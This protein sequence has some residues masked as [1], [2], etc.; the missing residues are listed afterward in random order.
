MKLSCGLLLFLLLWSISAMAVG[1]NP[2]HDWRSFDSQH[3]VVHFEAEDRPQALQAA[4][5]AERVL[6]GIVKDLHW[7]PRSKTHLI[8]F[9][10]YD[11]A[12]GFATPLPFS[13][14]GIFL[15]PP[16]DGELLENS[17]WLEL[18]ISHELVHIVHL[19]KVRGAPKFLQNIFG[20]YPL[21][22][23]NA[24]QPTWLIEGLATYHESE[25][26]QHRGRLDNALSDAYMRLE[27][28]NGAK[29]L[30]E[31]NSSGR[32]FPI[33]KAYLY[34]AYFYR[35]LEQRYGADA[36]YRLVENYSDNIIPF[37][38]HSN[39]VAVTKK[40]MDELWLE[41][42]Q[43][44]NERFGGA[45]KNAGK[46]LLAEPAWQLETPVLAAD[47]SLYAVADDGISRPYLSRL[48]SDGEW[49]HLQALQAGARIDIN[50]NGEVLIAQ[51]EICDNYHYYYD[52]YRWSDADGLTRLSQCGRYRF[53]G[54]RG[55]NALLALRNDSGRAAV[56]LLDRNGKETQTL[57][58]AADSEALPA[59]AVSQDG[60]R[61][62]WLSKHAGQWRVQELQLADGSVQ[63][64]LRSDTALLSLRYLPEN[65]DLLWV[66][67]QNGVFNVERW[68]RASTKTVR[69][70]DANAAVLA[71]SGAQAGRF[72]SL[73]LVHGGYQLYQHPL[74]ALAGSPEAETLT[75]S[76]AA[77]AL[78]TEA[79]AAEVVTTTTT[80]E[81]TATGANP[82][83]L[84]VQDERDYSA[85]ETLAPRAW[86]PTAMVADGALAF[87]VEL[88]GQDAIGWHQYTLSPQYEFSEGELLG[89]LV[90]GYDQR[91]F[92][93]V[94][95]EM[96]VTDSIEN[97]DDEE[98]IVSYELRTAAQWIS[99]APWLRL[100]HRL[101]FGIGA[102]MA[103]ETYELV[104]V[105]RITLQ[106]EKLAAAFFSYDSRRGNWWSEGNNS[107]QYLSLLAESYD[108]FDGE[109]EGRVYRA[110]WRG[111]WA[112]GVTSLALR[113]T[114][115]KG[116]ERTEPFELGGSFNSEQFGIPRL[117]ERDL[118]LRG[119]DNGEPE[120]TGKRA[121]IAGIEWRTPLV[122]LDRHLMVPPI[123]LNRLSA[124]LFYEAGA[125]WTDASKPEQYYRSAG[126][127]LL[128]ELKLGYRLG[129]L[130]R[131][132]FAR[133]LDEPGGDEVYLQLGRSF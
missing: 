82:A 83:T 102:A 60:A 114:E 54:W 129:L 108:P 92:F 107:G 64:L 4:A 8:L 90:Y 27:V 101:R 119:Y 65:N 116:D 78:A 49:Q 112:L 13:H 19:D 34:G 2:S 58:Q 35:F 57:Y 118:A 126:V 133:G 128:A 53:A 51:P 121:R 11:L 70:T 36:V 75:E 84:T 81:V 115:A 40:P 106:D 9:D 5:I 76:A 71:V 117:N 125:A 104:D 18:V 72:V 12:N 37:R 47:G 98:E 50:S 86:F 15:T 132:G 24:W 16:D 63:T 28:Q 73:Q 68:S 10:D 7:Q 89:S 100:D 111:Q 14:T 32:A 120:L 43:W 39:P 44:L 31:I 25:P 59:L 29:S 127:E 93:A 124:A 96:E 69:L 46:A 122:D 88:F 62:A 85:L 110:D 130:L 17:D 45:E 131:A 66:R 52:L 61:V 6:P 123:G 77:S 91:H 97:D 22:F 55:E 21:L 105:G 109:Y 113:L 56:V 42:Q 80:S 3:F 23:P 74:T 99:M 94:F 41:F 20:R 26:S 67:D 87:G 38:V 103:R 48:G 1:P 33:N 30:R 95:R 79:G